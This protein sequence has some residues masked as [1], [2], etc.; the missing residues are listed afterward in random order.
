MTV[1]SQMAELQPRID[2]LEATCE[3]AR[4]ELGRHKVAL[5]KLSKERNDALER[6]TQVRSSKSD[7][8]A[9][10]AQLAAQLTKIR[11]E[12]EKMKKQADIVATA[13]TSQQTEVEKLTDALGLLETELAN[14]VD[15]SPMQ[16]D[17]SPMHIPTTHSYMK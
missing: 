2:E 14:Q 6:G 12:P 5:Q 9:Q 8:E 4:S 3:E 13:V 1:C 17:P 15:P 7:A 11:G 10:R 16:L